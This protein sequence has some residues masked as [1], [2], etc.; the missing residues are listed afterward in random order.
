MRAQTGISQAGGV[1]AEER[2][3]GVDGSGENA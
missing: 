1:G 3:R 2:V